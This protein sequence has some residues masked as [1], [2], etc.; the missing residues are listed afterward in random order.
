MKPLLV[1]LAA[2]ILYTLFLVFQADN[3]LY[4]LKV[5]E[6]KATADDCSAAA[7]L[8]YDINEFNK[9]KKIYNQS[10]GNKVIKYLIKNNLCVNDELKPI[11]NTYWQDTLDYYV[12]YI[13][14]SEY[15]TRYH[16]Q[17]MIRKSPFKYGDL[18]QDDTANYNKVITEPMIIVTIDAGQGRFRLNLLNNDHIQA[19]RSSGYEYV[20]R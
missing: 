7:S 16:N 6:V 4:L 10:E 2:M 18:Y 14:D 3:N 17:K 20:D 11:E 5:N 9:G 15:I 13:D 12:A 8:Y 19:I 1:G